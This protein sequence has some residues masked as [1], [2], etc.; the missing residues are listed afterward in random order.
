MGQ[1]VYYVQNVSSINIRRISEKNVWNKSESVVAE[2]ATNAI[3]EV[4]KKISLFSKNFQ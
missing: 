3:K 1:S 2:L 4:L